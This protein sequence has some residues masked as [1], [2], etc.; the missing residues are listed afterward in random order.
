MKSGFRREMRQ[1]P[2]ELP[3]HRRHGVYANPNDAPFS[4]V[5]V[6]VPFENVPEVAPLIE[7]IEHAVC[8]NL[9]PSTAT[10]VPYKLCIYGPGGFFKAHVDTPT[11]SAARM[12][13]TAVVALPSAFSGGELRVHAPAGHIPSD[14]LSSGGKGK[15]GVASFDWGTAAIVESGAPSELDSAGGITEGGPATGSKLAHGVV[16]DSTMPWAAFFGDCVHEVLP[17]TAGR[18][19]TSTF[20]PP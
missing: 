4:T 14:M 12:L 18:P 13:G 3:Q 17:V 10:L 6:D 9:T 15:G 2:R 5:R 20:L 16:A 1:G 8:K 19:T 7:D 11:L